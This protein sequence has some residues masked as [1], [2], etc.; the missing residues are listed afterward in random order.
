MAASALKRA[1]DLKW[2]IKGIL[3]G[4]GGFLY[5]QVKGQLKALFSENNS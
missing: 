1:N 4:E 2:V 5:E 3:T